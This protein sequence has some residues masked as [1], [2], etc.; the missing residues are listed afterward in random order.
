M[1]EMTTLRAHPQF[2]MTRLM[3]MFVRIGRVPIRILVNPQLTP[4][5]LK[6]KYS[7]S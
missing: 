4:P 5:T 3:F 2:G 1:S 7:D 6:I